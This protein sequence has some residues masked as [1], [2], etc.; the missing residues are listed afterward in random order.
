MMIIAWGQYIH[1]A[2]LQY[3]R[4]ASIRDGDSDSHQIGV[5]AHWLAAEY[6]VLE[7]WRELGI[8]DKRVSKLIQLYPENCE[9]LRRCRN[10][11]YHFQSEIL[12]RRIINCLQNQNE[13]AA[14][15]IALHYEFQRLLIAY[16]YALSGT[17]EEQ[18]EL[19]D[20]MAHCIGW[21]PE[22][23]PTYRKIE[24]LRK[25]MKFQQMLASNDSPNKEDASR[26]VLAT[27]KQLAEIEDAPFASKLARWSA[28]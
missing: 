16:P 21:M 28:D 11:V 12:D 4:F 15:S 27:L 17:I 2:Q 14:W 1:W 26:L 5:F 18:A 22:R 24:L 9:T 25:C 20:E 7:G 19:A 3:E 13:E 23:N 10:A 6:V 8:T